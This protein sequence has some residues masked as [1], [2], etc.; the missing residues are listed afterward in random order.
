MAS[1]PYAS[2]PPDHP[3][4]SVGSTIYSGSDGS[5][6]HSR[7]PRARSWSCESSPGPG[8]L[9]IVQGDDLD[10]YLE[11]QRLLAANRSANQGDAVSHPFPH[12]FSLNHGDS[13]CN[14]GDGEDMTDEEFFAQF[15]EEG[16]PEWAN[17]PFDAAPQVQGDGDGDGDHLM[18]LNVEDLEAQLEAETPAEDDHPRGLNPKDPE[19][20]PEAEM[21]AEDD[22]LIELSAA[23]FNSET[24]AEHDD[25][26]REAQLDAEIGVE[27]EVDPMEIFEKDLRIQ[28]NRELRAERILKR[29]A[30]AVRPKANLQQP[31][32][33]APENEVLEIPTAQEDDL[34]EPTLEELEAELN[35]GDAASGTP[36]NISGTFSVLWTLHSKFDPCTVNS[37]PKTQSEK[38]TNE[39][40]SAPGTTKKPG[41]LGARVGRSKPPPMRRTDDLPQLYHHQDPINWTPLRKAITLSMYHHPGAMKSPISPYRSVCVAFADDE[42][43]GTRVDL[44]HCYKS[45]GLDVGRGKAVY[46]DLKA[47]LRIPGNSVDLSAKNVSANDAKRIIARIAHRLLINQGWGQ[48]YFNRPS[49]TSGCKYIPF[50]ANSTE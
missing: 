13:A 42:F 49:L 4:S 2:D 25:E 22:D 16:V 14:N 26:D 38:R 3:S 21:A 44:N 30:R 33:I 8:P 10:E 46:E 24:A 6:R 1:T 27:H 32:R 36:S 5:D 11:E 15:G 41:P 9:I 40:K 18:G 43:S 47:Y 17:Q 31:I 29:A 37:Y 12:D 28:L 20:Q 48:K 39:K 34:T 7:S 45:L 19:V 35:G 23:Q 50:D